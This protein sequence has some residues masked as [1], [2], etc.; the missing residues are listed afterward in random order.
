MDENTIAKERLFADLYHELHRLAQR[1]LRRDGRL[2]PIS[3]TTLLHESYLSVSKVDFADSQRF[4]AYAARTMRGLV[5]DATRRRRALK[6]GGAFVMTSF[7]ADLLSDH[8]ESAT[9]EHDLIRIN[10]ALEEL[11]AKDSA[12]AELVQLRY[13][14]GLS[15][16]Q[17]GALRGVTQRTVQRQWEKARLL[18]FYMLKHPREGVPS[19]HSLGI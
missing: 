5:I 9:H 15:L 14:C 10:D 19:E 16:A 4:L 6:Y 8:E 7:E 13:F 1:E 18:L 3:A 17:I 11:E 2:L 12:L